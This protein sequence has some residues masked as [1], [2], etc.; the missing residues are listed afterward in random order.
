MAW[1]AQYTVYT[2]RWDQA[3]FR[4]PDIPLLLLRTQ[5]EQPTQ[6][7][8]FVSTPL[9]HTVQV[10]FS[11]F[12]ST[13]IPGPDIRTFVLSMLTQS[14]FHP[15]LVFLRISFSCDSSSDS[16]MMTRSSAYRFSQGHSVGKSWERASR[17][18]TNSR[19]SGKI[20]GEHPLSHG[21][22]HSG[23]NQH[24]LCFLQFHACSVW[25]APDDTPGSTKAVFSVLL[26]AWVVSCNWCTMNMASVMLRPG[27]KTNRMPSMGTCYHR[28]FSATLSRTLMTWSSN[29]RCQ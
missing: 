18:T 4:W 19:V 23:C 2:W 6:K 14:P 1:P 8:K 26:M 20:L 22:L 12:W 3:C 11:D 10:F 16:E 21:T 24:G 27:I 28:K 13:S 7:T 17:T 9:R 5:L 29:L 25:A 15:M